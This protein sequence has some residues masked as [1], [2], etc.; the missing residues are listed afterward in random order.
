MLRNSAEFTYYDLA[1]IFKQ[2]QIINLKENFAALGVSV[3][4]RQVEPG[5]IFVAL[6]GEKLDAHSK[7]GEAF[8]RGATL[9]VVEGPWYAENAA[10]FIDKSFIVVKETISALGALG[11]H[12]RERFSIPIVAV[13]GS[14]GK[15]TTKDMAAAVLSEKYKTLKTFEN[16]NNQLGVPL[17]LLQLS[18]EYEAAA[19]EIGTNEPGEI[20][21]LS[22]MVRPTSGVITNIGKEHLEK[23]IDLDGVEFEET[24]LYG[25]LRK[26]NKTA[27]INIDDERL[28]KYARLMDNKITYGETNAGMLQANIILTEELKPI[29]K[30]MYGE[31]QIEIGLPTYG[32]VSALNALAASAVGIAH[33]VP[34]ESIKRALENFVPTEGHGYARMQVEP[35]GDSL[36][37][38]DCYN[39]NPNSMAA[40]LESLAAL[41][42]DYYKIAALGDMRELGE[43][44]ADEHERL[45]VL[46]CEK[47]DK[48]YLHGEELAK[49]SARSNVNGKAQVFDDKPEM[50]KA[51]RAQV[52]SKRAAILVKGSRGMKMEELIALLRSNN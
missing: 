27:L 41:P 12:H 7:V 9:C 32:R 20:G 30:L 5:N 40:A 48:V 26:N 51:I 49:A 38:N 11:R 43:A 46:A 42:G 6:R 39:S 52:I 16:F 25:F 33:G 17:M 3:D 18:G 24:F 21:I 47:A 1:S 19:L 44:A 34:L 36:I 15:T 4:T 23:L 28:A 13:A 8:E 50:A 2:S 22:E 37:I 35:L 14:N 31:D 10:R 29:L 45:I